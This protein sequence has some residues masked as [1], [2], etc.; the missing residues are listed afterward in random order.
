ME[1]V[2][3][4]AEGILFHEGERL[5][6]KRI[7]KGYRLEELDSEIRRF[8]TRREGR[9]MERA[10]KLISVP[11]VFSINERDMIIKM[12]F[13]KGE[14]LSEKLDSFDEKKRIAVCNLIGKNV[15]LLHNKDII[16][17][18]LTTSNMILKKDKL[19]FIDFGL[20]FIDSKAEHKAVD[21]HLL[22]QALESKHYENFESSFSAVLEGYKKF[23]KE[24]KKIISR[25]NQVEERGRYKRKK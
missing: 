2:A 19:Y 25:F 7:K 17:G 24:Y 1:I 13:I 4:G 16:H 12:E 6:K 15:A 14:K 22:K 23:S 9:L 20:G 21:L 11:R 8:R 3:R 5:V 18:D 10:S